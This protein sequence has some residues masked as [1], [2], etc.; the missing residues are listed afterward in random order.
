MNYIY[1]P[2]GYIADFTYKVMTNGSLNDNHGCIFMTTEM[3][4]AKFQC[5]FFVFFSPLSS[6]FYQLSWHQQNRYLLDAEEVF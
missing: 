4:E 1:C 5:F 6:D 3:M 2:L